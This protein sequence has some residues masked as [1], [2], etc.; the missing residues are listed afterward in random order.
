MNNTRTSMDLNY[1]EPQDLRVK[2][3]SYDNFRMAIYFPYNAFAESLI[4]GP[5]RMIN[6]EFFR[7]YRK[8]NKTTFTY[9]DAVWMKDETR[10]YFELKD[11]EKFSVDQLMRMKD[12][13]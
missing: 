12:G 11:E 10:N 2:I 7:A 4:I 5:E 8:E 3:R 1:V 13:T 9:Y 6:V